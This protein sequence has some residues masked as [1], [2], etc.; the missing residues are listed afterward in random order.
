MQDIFEIGDSDT[1]RQFIDHAVQGNALPSVGNEALFGSLNKLFSESYGEHTVHESDVLV[2]ALKSEARRRLR[3]FFETFG[4]KVLSCAFRCESGEVHIYLT[5]N[6][7]AFVKSGMSSRFAPEQLQ[8]IAGN[9]NIQGVKFS[10][11]DAPDKLFRN[12]SLLNAASAKGGPSAEKLREGVEARVTD[13][14]GN[15]QNV[16]H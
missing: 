7:V 12:P 3:A 11:S 14:L 15:G 13:L 2:E 1:L 10:A 9:P 16:I 4:H 5:F 8:D 6:R